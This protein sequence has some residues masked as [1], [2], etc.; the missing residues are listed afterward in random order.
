MFAQRIIMLPFNY[1]SLSVRIPLIHRHTTDE[2]KPCERIAH[3]EAL[4]LMETVRFVVVVRN[5][6]LCR[7]TAF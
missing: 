4:M 6:L 7:Y 5:M 1:T 2:C 3:A